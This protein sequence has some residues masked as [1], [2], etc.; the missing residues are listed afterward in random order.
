MTWQT[1]WRIAGGIA[2]VCAAVL[3]VYGAEGEFPRTS[4]VHFIVYW[5]LCFVALATAVFIAI[6]DIQYIRVQHAVAKRELVRSTLGHLGEEGRAAQE[7]EPAEETP[8][9]GDSE[10]EEGHRNP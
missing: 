3:T 2:L 5:G 1:K 6:L 7:G 9:N 10:D 4:L 8:P